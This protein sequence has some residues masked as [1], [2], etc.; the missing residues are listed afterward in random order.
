MYSFGE[1]LWR[2]LSVPPSA[3]LLEA[4]LRGTTVVHVACGGFHCGALSE[5]GGIY[6][7]GE[8]TAGQCGPSEGD[9]DSNVTGSSSPHF[10]YSLAS[11]HENLNPLCSTCFK[12]HF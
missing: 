8:N 11:F 1:L 2:G 9:S 5:Q 4:S 10:L 7:W 3:P 12:S 6:M